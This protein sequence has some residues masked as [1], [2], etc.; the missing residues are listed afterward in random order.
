M[1]ILGLLCLV[2]AFEMEMM[3]DLLSLGIVFAQC[4]VMDYCRC[5]LFIFCA[6]ICTVID[7]LSVLFYLMLGF[8][9]F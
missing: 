2:K 4:G 6:V 3:F 7:L 9:M 8:L 5:A 1:I